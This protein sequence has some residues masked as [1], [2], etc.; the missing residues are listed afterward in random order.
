MMGLQRFPL[1][2]SIAAPDTAARPRGK[3][4]LQGLRHGVLRVV[5]EIHASVTPLRGIFRAALI[6]GLAGGLRRQGYTRK[7]KQ[8]PGASNSRGTFS[9]PKARSQQKESVGS[10]LEF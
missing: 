10:G 3:T 4:P 8:G 6:A 5:P 1:P 9:Q 7:C 2:C